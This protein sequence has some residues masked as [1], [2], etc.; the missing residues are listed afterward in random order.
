MPTD[1]LA[2]L[3]ARVPC[4]SRGKKAALGLAV[5]LGVMQYRQLLKQEAPNV[6]RAMVDRVANVSGEG[7]H[8]AKEG[9][10]NQKSRKTRAKK[11]AILD[12]K[13]Q[14]KFKALLKISLRDWKSLSKLLAFT[15]TLL[16]RT[17][18]TMRMSSL[19]GIV[20]RNMIEKNKAAFNDSIAK[21]VVLSMPAAIINALLNY[22]A[23]SIAT[24]MRLNSNITDVDQRITQDVEEWASSAV[25]IFQNLVKPGIDVLLYS[26]AL[27]QAVGLGGPLSMLAYFLLSSIALRIMSPGFGRLTARLQKLMGF[28]R[29][30]HMRFAARTEEIAFSYGSRFERKT[31]EGAHMSHDAHRRFLQRQ[32]LLMAI[33]DNYII[34]YGATVV[35][36]A[37][38]LSRI[39][40][41]DAS[42]GSVGVGREAMDAGKITENFVR[43]SRMLTTL[44]DAIGRIVLSYKQVSVVA[45]FTTRVSAL[46][47]C[48]DNLERSAAIS[49]SSQK[50][51]S[52]DSIQ[53]QKLQ[54]KVPGS[55]ELLLRDLTTSIEKG[56]HTLIAGPNGCGKTC[57]LRVLRG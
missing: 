33:L 54:V 50:D 14:Q 38:V 35:G 46:V 31:I 43:S 56:N 3:L 53:F 32:S 34:K 2:A 49:K 57:L 13:F 8:G 4:M 40:F 26:R 24:D 23:S 29:F 41:P 44:S 28:Y 30:L 25:L 42:S 48:L 27:T 36:F 11:R 21:L 20:T 39:A 12:E 6:P 1:Q 19:L 18:V 52:K 47:E 22:L 9:K 55:K 10:I 15:L 5:I 16:A 45:G 17:Q 37:Y 7:D 51:E